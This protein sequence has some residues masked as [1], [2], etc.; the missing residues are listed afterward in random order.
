MEVLG[1]LIKGTLVKYWIYFCCSMFFVVS[2]SGKVVVY[3]ILYI[4]LF[5]FCIALY[6]VQQAG[7]C[8]D[9]SLPLR[10]IQIQIT[11]EKRFI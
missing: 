9:R 6:Q 7:L 11:H 5:L 1:S 2:F 3:K 4:M 8:R 10:Y